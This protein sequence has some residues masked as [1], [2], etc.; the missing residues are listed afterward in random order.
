MDKGELTGGKGC[1]GKRGKMNKSP[2]LKCSTF[3]E[4]PRSNYHV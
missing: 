1:K 2:I 4:V 3:K